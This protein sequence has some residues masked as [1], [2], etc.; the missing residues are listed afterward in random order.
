MDQK[1]HWAYPSLTRPGL[2]RG[3]LLEHFRHEYLVYVRDFPVLLARALGQ[4]PPLDDV[5]HALAENLYEEQTGGISKS[6]PHPELFLRMMEGLGYERSAFVDDDAWL[7][8][9][10]R[11][12]RDLL[13][14][15]SAGAPWQA[16]VALLTIFVEGS[17]NERKEL[18]GKHDRPKGD[19]A[20]ARHP[21]VL[22]YGCP[23]SAM[24]LTRAHAAVEGA[25]RG[26]AWRIVLAHVPDDGEVFQ[27]T[28]DL[29][30]RALA[31]WHRYRDA[32][33]DRMQLRRDASAA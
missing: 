4:V 15:A 22:H 11:A 14:E 29:A 12:Y 20:I 23:P 10:A 32:V 17:V 28:I 27:R 6:A 13:R 16:A 1:H 19:A 18:A 33:A 2:S 9:A 30:Q 25:H 7:H 26:D 8:P 3:Q 5:R 31:S 21:L 24:Q